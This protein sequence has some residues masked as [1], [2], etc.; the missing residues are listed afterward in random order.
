MKV[1][2]NFNL[3]LSDIAAAGEV[4]TFSITGTNGAVF[5]LQITN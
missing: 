2:R 1:I 3:D 4:R 5:S